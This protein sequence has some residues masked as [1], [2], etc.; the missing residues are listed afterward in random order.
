MDDQAMDDNAMDDHAA[1]TQP[2]R[3]TTTASTE[4]KG[5]VLQQL[6]TNQ[7]G[8]KSTKVKILFVCGNQRS[9]VT[10]SLKSKLS[11]KPTT[12]PQH[13]WRKERSKTKM[14]CCNF[15]S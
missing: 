7:D 11:L 6:A 15:A 8:S 5:H 14:R 3:I 13:I 2:Q 9:Y 4:T 1:N 12:S 10:D